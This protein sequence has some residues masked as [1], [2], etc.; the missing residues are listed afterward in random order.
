[1]YVRECCI[2]ETFFFFVYGGWRIISVINFVYLIV[3]IVTIPQKLNGNIS[4]SD[5][6]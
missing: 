5:F 4:T 1:M 2:K 3:D 6:K